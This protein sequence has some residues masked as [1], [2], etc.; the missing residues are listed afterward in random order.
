[1]R[2]YIVFSIV[3]LILNTSQV[4][5]Q[6]NKNMSK[7]FVFKL[8]SKIQGKVDSLYLDETK[9]K[10]ISHDLESNLIS[11]KYYTAKSKSELAEIINEEFFYQTKDRHF[12]LKYYPSNLDQKESLFSFMDVLQ[13]ENYGI[14][15]VEYFLGNIGYFKLDRI[16]PPEILNKAL[17]PTFNLIKNATS[18]IIDLRDNGGGVDSDYLCG[19]FLG[20]EKRNLGYF[21]YRNQPNEE[22]CTSPELCPLQL[23][24]ADLY[25][26][27]SSRTFSAAEAFAYNLQSLNRVTIVGE[28]TGGGGNPAISFPIEK[29]FWISIPFGYSVNAITESNW[30]GKGV[31]PDIVVPE[32]DALAATIKEIS[33]RTSDTILKKL[34]HYVYLQKKAIIDPVEITPL[35]FKSYEGT[36]GQLTITCMNN[37]VYISRKHGISYKLTPLGDDIFF[38]SGSNSFIEISDNNLLIT[39]SDQSLTQ[40]SRTIAN[41]K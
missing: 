21:K 32:K 38:S 20:K 9:G 18:I 3:F 15:N 26:L 41:K 29:D 8:V 22:Q 17:E 28:V 7:E 6:E 2:K 16:P 12:T 35:Q 4:Q 1:M 39:N 31:Q 5:G 37:T 14:N 10:I 27:T 36:Y 33:T 13:M 25:L 34:Y 24:S 30:E 11:G 40:E 19:C 23:D